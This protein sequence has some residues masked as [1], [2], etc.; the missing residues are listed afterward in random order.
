[1]HHWQGNYILAFPA[2]ES[3]ISR[4]KIMSNGFSGIPR[5]WW[6]K[7]IGVFLGLMRG[8]ISGAIL[9]G[10]MGHMADRFFS[11]LSGG[12]GTRQV[13]FRA[14]FSTLGHINKADGRVTQAE[15]KAAEALMRRLDLNTEEKKR[16]VRYFEQ[17]KEPDFRLEQ[18]LRQFAQ[19]TIVRHDLRQMFV[20]ILLDGASADGNISSA[21]QAVLARVC[22][23]LHIPAELFAAMLNARRTSSGG[24]RQQ[25][26]PNRRLPIQQAYASLGINESVSDAEVKKAYRKLVR[27]YHPDKLVSRGLPEEMMKKAKT[28]VREINGAYD[29]IKQSRGFK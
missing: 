6:G 5:H 11:G 3:T 13:F 19:H 7:I 14:L 23:A 25:Q 8:G 26:S 17:G 27:Q 18:N 1:M 22:T 9:G 15:I 10:F 20:E 12:N 28:R 29:Q 16:A 24:Y 2:I 21:E 4:Q